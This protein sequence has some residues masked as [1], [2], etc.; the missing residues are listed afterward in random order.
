[1]HIAVV[2]PS[3]PAEFVADLATGEDFP[4]G[5]GG[6]PVNGLVR[7]LLDLGHKVSLITASPGLDSIWRA[8]GPSLSIVAVPYRTRARHRALDF[9]HHERAAMAKEIA[10]C[11]ADVY[12][13][14]WTYEFALAC[15]DAGV[16][17]LL[18]T[19]HDA[20]LTI[21]KH[22]PDPYRLIRAL[23][24]FRVRLSIRHLT[25]VSPYLAGR[26]RREMLF[27]RHIAEI[28]NSIPQLEF[29]ERPEANHAVILDVANSS[30]LKNV[31]A[32]LRAFPTVREIHPDAELRLVGGGLG[33]GDDM[34][35]WALENG[36]AAGVHF[37]GPLSRI[38]I[39][40]QFAEAT[41]FCHPSLEESQ[42]ICFLE[43]MSALV[44][45]IGGS[46]S[47]GV[48]WTLFQGEAGTLVDVSVPSD[49]A[50]AILNVVGDTEK[51]RLTA[52]HALGLLNSRFSP[53]VV[54]R[55]YL[56]EYARVAA[57]PAES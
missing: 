3:D 29:P 17:P 57:L 11:D 55:Q 37:L 13:A 56:A 21:L 7:S 5:M 49:I 10:Q 27:R 1:M 45:V 14:H 2:G 47:G 15:I 48:P 43:A 54:A 33:R 53:M 18:V 24:A 46:E 12:H 42:G 16:K 8:N 22:L 31:K 19:A 38:E 26:W 50:Q 52:E 40:R 4:K 23:I 28:A 34:E 25:A 41:V 35:L 51:S 30:G 20:P 44:P 39:G 32:L 36:L 6:T 9:F